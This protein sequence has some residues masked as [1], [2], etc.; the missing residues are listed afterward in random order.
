MIMIG[1]IKILDNIIQTLKSIVTYQNKRLLSSILVVI[2]QFMFYTIVKKV[3]S[4]S[5]DNVIIV[6]SIASGIG[7]YLAFIISDYFKKDSVWTNDIT[8][9]D[10]DML[11]ELA[12]LMKDNKIKYLLFNTYNRK[13]EESLTIKIYAKTRN[14]SKIIDR[15]LEQTDARYLRMI[16]GEQV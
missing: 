5:V 3:M 13:F 12:T 2:S 7:N 15:F 1:F 8:S 4:D 16:D 11:I 9:S 14:Q 10:K 6:V